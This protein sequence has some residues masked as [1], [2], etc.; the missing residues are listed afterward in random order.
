MEVRDPFCSAEER[1][2]LPK[3]LA[4]E[5]HWQRREATALDLIGGQGARGSASCFECPPNGVP[6]DLLNGERKL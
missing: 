2:D 3:W 1:K 6:Q 4:T 5:V